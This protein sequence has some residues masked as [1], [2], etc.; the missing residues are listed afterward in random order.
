MLNVRSKGSAS[1]PGVVSVKS[2]LIPVPSLNLISE[3]GLIRTSVLSPSSTINEL[4][5][6]VVHE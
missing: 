2:M 1:E 4:P 3:L 5:A 6:G